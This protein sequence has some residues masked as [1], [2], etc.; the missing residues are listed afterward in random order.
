MTSLLVYNIILYGQLGKGTSF[1][2]MDSRSGCYEG[3]TLY[4]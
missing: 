2:T 3:A 1:N 4:A